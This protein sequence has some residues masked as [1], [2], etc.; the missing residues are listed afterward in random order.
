MSVELEHGTIDSL[1][2]ITND[3]PFMTYKITLAHLREYKDDYK[4]LAIMEDILKH[5]QFEQ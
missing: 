3:N 4:V 1:T 2:N 5:H